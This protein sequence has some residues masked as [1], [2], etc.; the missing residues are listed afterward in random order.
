[1]GSARQKL[2]VGW[3]RTA[4]GGRLSVPQGRQRLR[5]RHGLASGRAPIERMQLGALTVGAHLA[6]A[7]A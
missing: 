7:D 1:M 4:E 2:N 3:R 6:V 5:Q